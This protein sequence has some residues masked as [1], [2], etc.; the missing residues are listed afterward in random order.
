M[1]P[2]N[3]TSYK[4]Y[5]RNFF[6]INHVSAD[7]INEL[8]KEYNQY[9]ETVLAATPELVCRIIYREYTGKIL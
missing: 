6:E 8:M 9:I 4:R 1:A 2:I 3:P 5:M 7:L